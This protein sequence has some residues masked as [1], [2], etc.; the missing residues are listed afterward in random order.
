MIQGGSGIFL[1]Y[2]FG[3]N[4]NVTKGFDQ[5]KITG[6]FMIGLAKVLMPQ[7][8]SDKI[9]LHWFFNLSHLV[10]ILTQQ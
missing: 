5:G 9:G 1:E 6:M 10:V 2:V 4:D 8:S 7:S 3:L